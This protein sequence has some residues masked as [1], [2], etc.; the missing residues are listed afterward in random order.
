MQKLDGGGG[1]LGDPAVAGAAGLRDREAQPWPHAH[2]ARE[3]RVPQGGCQ[4]GR[5]ARIHG[6]ESRLKR[7]FDLR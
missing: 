3:H 1:T 5:T 6:R 4:A 7:P 2:A